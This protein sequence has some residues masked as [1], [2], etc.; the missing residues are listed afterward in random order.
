MSLPGKKQQLRLVRL[1]SALPALTFQQLCPLTGDISVRLLLGAGRRV[2]PEDSPWN[3]CHRR[4]QRGSE[5]ASFPQALPV[6]HS[7]PAGHRMDRVSEGCF[8]DQLL[9]QQHRRAGGTGTALEPEAQKEHDPR[10]TTNPSAG[11]EEAAP[12]DPQSRDR[13]RAL[14]QSFG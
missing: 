12:Q 8:S 4:K 1:L 11:N 3:P 2:A 9:Q 10:D 6:P 5:K 13:T 7:A 14:Y